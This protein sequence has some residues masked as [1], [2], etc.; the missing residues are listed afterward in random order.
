MRQHGRRMLCQHERELRQLILNECF[1]DKKKRT[2]PL[3]NRVLPLTVDDVERFQSKHC[4]CFGDNHNISKGRGLC[5]FKATKL[6]SKQS[7]F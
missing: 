1:R 2:S 5:T 6:Y 7:T 3:N 4:F